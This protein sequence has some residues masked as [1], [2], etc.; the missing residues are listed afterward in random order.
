[1]LL[2]CKSLLFIVN[3][4]L[5]FVIFSTLPQIIKIIAKSYKKVPCIGEPHKWDLSTSTKI[6]HTYHFYISIFSVFS[7][8]SVEDV[9]LTK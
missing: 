4:N 3:Q 6:I 7:S 2:I 9:Q 5:R 8:R 1:M